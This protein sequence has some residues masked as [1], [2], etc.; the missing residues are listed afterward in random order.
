MR[1]L[2]DY[3]ES[4]GIPVLEGVTLTPKLVGDGRWL[5]FFEKCVCFWSCDFILTDP[6]E[7]RK[8]FVFKPRWTESA[9]TRAKAFALELPTFIATG[10]GDRRAIPTIRGVRDNGGALVGPRGCWF[11]PETTGSSNVI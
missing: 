11:G 3:Y 9:R 5:Q 4:K 2:K 1:G 10:Q 7:P 6:A 8:H